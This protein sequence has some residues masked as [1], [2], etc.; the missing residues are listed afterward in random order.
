MDDLDDFKN[1][2][3]PSELASIRAIEKELFDHPDGVSRLS[4][5]L[6]V[7]RNRSVYNSR[8]KRDKD[9][10]EVDPRRIQ[11][12]LKIMREGYEILSQELPELGEVGIR[13]YNIR[14][15]SENGPSYQLLNPSA[16]LFPEEANHHSATSD[17][18]RILYSLATAYGFPVHNVLIHTFPGL[19]EDQKAID[20]YQT[21]DMLPGVAQKFVKLNSAICRRQ[22]IRFKYGIKE[23]AELIVSPLTLRRDEGKWYL[24]AHINQPDAWRWTVFGLDERMGDEITDFT[25]GPHSEFVDIPR[26]EIEEYYRHIY[27]TYVP[28]ECM[29]GN[30]NKDMNAADLLT[31]DV[32]FTVTDKVMLNY[33]KWNPL[34]P[35]QE[36]RGRRVTIPD[37]VVSR[38]LALRLLGRGESLEDVE[39]DA[40]RTMMLQIAEEII[41]KLK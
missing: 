31:Y 3:S 40:L 28:K 10:P 5:Q 16:L 13:R 1:S 8:S 4:L 12:L 11:Y 6:V 35:A 17:L 37:I 39:P 30:Y 23:K 29:G 2:L 18:V 21:T 25:R 36:I 26:A 7:G 19:K 33:L 22:V 27:G 20:I 14:T 9:T 41:K 34:H 24:L 32:S 38:P 15:D